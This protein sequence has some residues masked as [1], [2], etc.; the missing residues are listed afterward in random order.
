MDRVDTL[1]SLAGTSVSQ[2][3]LN[4]GNAMSDTDYKLT[5]SP[6]PISV[7]QGESAVVTLLVSTFDPFVGPL[8]LSAETSHPSI[9]VSL[10]NNQ[11]N[12]QPGD[13]VEISATI[14][15]D[16]SLHANRHSFAILS[17]DASGNQKT[18]VHYVDVIGPDFALS[19]NPPSV[20]M[21]SGESFVPEITIDSIEGHIGPI[22]L[23][24]TSPH[25]T[26]TTTLSSN[27]VPLP[28]NGFSV[29]ELTLDTT[30]ATP[31]GDY[32]VH[33]TGADAEVTRSTMLT[34]NVPPVI[35]LMT[36]LAP[37]T[38]DKIGELGHFN[39]DFTVENLGNTSSD[40]IVWGLYLSTDANV[41]TSDRVLAEDMIFL[42]LEALADTPVSK[43]ITLPGDVVEG[44]YYLGVIIDNSDSAA[45]QNKTN[46]TAS[47]FVSI[48][49]FD[50]DVTATSVTSNK[51]SLASGESLTLTATV[52]NQGSNTANSVNVDFYLSQ[53]GNIDASDFL[54]GS[55]SLTLNGV[56]EGTVSVT[57]PAT[58]AA[59][60]YHIGVIVD[61]ANAIDE[62]DEGNN[63]LSD[64]TVNV[65]DGIDLVV[66][67][68][69]VPP[70]AALGE[71]IN[72]DL[73]ITNQGG[74]D[75]QGS[76]NWHIYLSTDSTITTADRWL[77][78]GYS[79]DLAAGES[80]ADSRAKAL[81]TD[82]APGQYY[83]GVIVDRWDAVDESN[84]T[85]NTGAV[86]IDITA[87][88]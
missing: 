38:P 74:A 11:V 48:V 80:H 68:V 58:V 5:V 43:E 49:D 50:A 17:T 67:G 51:A 57:A 71:N 10:N 33:I 7:R 83:I 56:S 69:T 73:V 16:A 13:V 85:N 77:H 40:W 52:A 26:I 21:M 60:Q 35:D 54:L 4:I 12:A 79:T 76:T 86:A 3:R 63:V 32:Q 29:S 47:K 36:A 82:I 31:A 20:T 28:A 53:D 64:G 81:P 39:V 1:P 55:N 6:S 41:T 45:E 8:T 44:S 24:V 46:N 78:F 72:I 25:P 34:V 22:S 62:S 75:L 87:S 65:A 37:T 70:T 42:E 18:A 14:S 27:L 2:G 88:Q 59:G 66:S 30:V 15:V 61:G 19:V 9:T 84:E 23:D